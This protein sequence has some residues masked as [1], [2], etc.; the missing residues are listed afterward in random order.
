MAVQWGGGGSVHH[1][2]SPCPGIQLLMSSCSYGDI[3]PREASCDT[4]VTGQSRAFSHPRS[5]GSLVGGAPNARLLALAHNP[6]HWHTWYH[7]YSLSRRGFYIY[8]LLCRWT[9][10]D[11]FC[12]IFRLQNRCMTESQ[13]WVWHQRDPSFS[14]WPGCLCKLGSP[15]NVTQQ[16]CTLARPQRLRAHKWSLVALPFCTST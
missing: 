3:P 7:T 11:Q 12:Q 10:C 6:A 8:H 14:H 2:M 16:G 5:T 9:L 1:V 15:I 13:A 4:R